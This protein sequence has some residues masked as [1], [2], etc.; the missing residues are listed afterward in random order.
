[1][2]NKSSYFYLKLN[3]PKE[4]RN[5]YE[6][7]EKLNNSIDEILYSMNAPTN[8]DNTHF[9]QSDDK[10]SLITI[11]RTNNRKR[12]GQLN[13]FCDRYLDESWN[14]KYTAESLKADEIPAVLGKI[15]KSNKFKTAY[16]KDED[17]LYNGRDIQV[18]KDKENWHG[19]QKDLYKMLFNKENNYFDIKIPHDRH[20]I[21]LVDIKGNSGKS[22]FWKFI[23]TRNRKD[24]ARLTYGTTGQLRAA[25]TALGEK[26]IYI[27]DLT[28][29]MGK[30]DE[31]KDLLAIIE[32]IKSGLIL[33]FFF[34][35]PRE[36]VAE[37]PH[38]ILSSNFVFQVI[39]Y[40][41]MN[42]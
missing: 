3:I 15:K 6:F 9:L 21:S 36:L 26:K 5:S 13:K 22:S 7:R 12:K 16:F 40:L 1:M 42:V 32:D 33:S 30:F 34:G 35:R 27:I 37:P 31:P 41:M 39:L 20:I 28:R 14:I 23:Y 19:W 29:T 38:I 24:I 18:F 8:D 25:I 4:Y 11:F 17:D 2:E 10:S